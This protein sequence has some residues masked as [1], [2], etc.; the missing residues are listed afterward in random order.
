VVG[1]WPN[2]APDPAIAGHYSSEDDRRGGRQMVKLA[3]TALAVLA[4][5]E[6]A[7]GS[8]EPRFKPR[9]GLHASFRHRRE[10]RKPH[11]RVLRDG[12]LAL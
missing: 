11:H 9:A 10:N 1:V 2:E 4:L 12:L 7:L 6:T 5:S 3:L 8:G